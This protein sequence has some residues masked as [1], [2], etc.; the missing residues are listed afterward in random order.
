MHSHSR[1]FKNWI[2]KNERVLE[3]IW[4]SGLLRLCN[5]IEE[6]LIYHYCNK[7]LVFAFVERWHP[8]MITFYF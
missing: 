8:E 1:P 6:G 2:V 5:G 4:G 7:V 3:R